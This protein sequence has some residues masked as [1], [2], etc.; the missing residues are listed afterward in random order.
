M[1]GHIM[2]PWAFINNFTFIFFILNPKLTWNYIYFF[3]C[4]FLST[5]FCMQ[6]SRADSPQIWNTMHD[7]RNRIFPPNC[8]DFNCWSQNKILILKW[9]M[10]VIYIISYLLGVFTKS[11]KQLLRSLPQ[12]YLAHVYF[13]KMDTNTRWS[14][15]QWEFKP[16]VHC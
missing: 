8:C 16:L 4:N 5:L 11:K 15:Y 1:C 13:E 3:Q 7:L 6:I 2:C 10:N 14:C 9:N 12:Q